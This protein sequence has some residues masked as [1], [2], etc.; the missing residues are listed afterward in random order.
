[1]IHLLCSLMSRIRPPCVRVCVYSGAKNKCAERNQ[2]LQKK[3]RN[4]KLAWSKINNGQKTKAECKK[5]WNIC[6]RILKNGAKANHNN[7]ASWSDLESCV[8]FFSR[9]YFILSL[10][11]VF[12]VFFFICITFSRKL[13]LQRSFVLCSRN[14]NSL[15]YGAPTIKSTKY[16][17]CSAIIIKYCGADKFTFSNARTLAG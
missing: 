3:Y 10:L 16:L 11:I 6:H 13:L 12:S 8:L 4:W 17:I 5:H 2:R 14:I 7:C 1:M 15:A 9:V